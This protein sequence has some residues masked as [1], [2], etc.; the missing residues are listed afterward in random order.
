MGQNKVCLSVGHFQN[1]AN[2]S[3]ILRTSQPNVFQEDNV[4]QKDNAG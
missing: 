3:C 1:Y 4:I 2:V